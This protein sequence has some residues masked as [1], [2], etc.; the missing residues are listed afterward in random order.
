MFSSFPIN[1]DEK[2]AEAD[3]EDEGEDGDGDGGDRGMEMGLST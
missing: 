2:G 3:A 1:T